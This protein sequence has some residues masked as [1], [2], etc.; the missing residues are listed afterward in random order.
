MTRLPAHTIM[1]HD[2]R[3]C[4]EGGSL[5]YIVKVLISASIIVAISEIAKRSTF[6]AA[7]VASIPLTSILAFIWI[8]VESGDI[9]KIGAL[10]TNIFWLGMPS[11][12]FFVVLPILLKQGWAFW[13]AM[14]VSITLTAAL[15]ALAI[16][17]FRRFGI[18]G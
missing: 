2:I 14:L 17:L 13:Q 16:F 7:I 10:S 1:L 11:F 9:H 15:Y 3:T 4:I 6:L 5:F 18:Y 8:Y 12:L